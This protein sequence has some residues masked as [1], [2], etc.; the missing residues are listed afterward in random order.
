M[1]TAPTF[2]SFHPLQATWPARN[3]MAT[4]GWT[5]TMKAQLTW[6][7]STAENCQDWPMR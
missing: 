2:P 1:D 6:D 7:L 5:T 4:S 3:V